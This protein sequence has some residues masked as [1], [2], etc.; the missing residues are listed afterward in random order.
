MYPITFIPVSLFLVYAVADCVLP[1]CP[2][3]KRLLILCIR[4]PFFPSSTFFSGYFCTFLCSLTVLHCAR[5]RSG[6]VRCVVLLQT[7][8]CFCSVFFLSPPSCGGAVGRV[9]SVGDLHPTDKSN[10]SDCASVDTKLSTTQFTYVANNAVVL[11]CART[12][13]LSECAHQLCA[14]KQ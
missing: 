11:G 3:L 7:R 12:S 1:T 10:C 2:G 4:R 8:S 13:S 14:S 5:S 6:G 9:P